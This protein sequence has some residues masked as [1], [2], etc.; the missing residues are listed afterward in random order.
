MFETGT[1]VS[2]IIAALVQWFGPWTSRH[3][4]ECQQPPPSH[5]NGR[6]VIAQMTNENE[7]LPIRQ[8]CVH[9]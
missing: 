6:L 3:C 5:P 4:T 2:T 1:T 8:P 7:G 9:Y